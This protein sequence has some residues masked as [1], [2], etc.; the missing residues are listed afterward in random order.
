MNIK[1]FALL[2]LTASAL[3][4][5]VSALNYEQSTAASSSGYSEQAIELGYDLHHADQSIEKVGVEA[6][7]RLQMSAIVDENMA[8]R[9]VW[10]RFRFPRKP[11]H[12]HQ[13]ARASHKSVIPP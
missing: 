6:D 1:K 2:L 12:Q 7:T 10:K 11:A 13:R 4:G 3:Y 8:A 5:S 9:E